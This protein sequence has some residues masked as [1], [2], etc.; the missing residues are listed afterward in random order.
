MPSYETFTVPWAGLAEGRYAVTEPTVMRG[1]TVR[2]A[3]LR[4]RD[5][6][7]VEATADEGEEALLFYLGCDGGARQLGE[8]SLTDRRLSPLRRFTGIGLLDENMGGRHGNCHIALGAAYPDCR[9]FRG[10]YSARSAE[11]YGFN[12]SGIHWDLVSTSPRT[13]HAKLKGGRELVIYRDG[14]FT[15]EA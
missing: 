5:G 6:R 9:T 10:K 15:F 1:E 13:V 4:F 11:R 2:G 14:E 3:R 12:R 8:F 7:V